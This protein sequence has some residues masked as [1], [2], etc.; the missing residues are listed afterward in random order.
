[1]QGYLTETWYLTALPQVLTPFR[2]SEASINLFLFYNTDD[3]SCY[4][5]QK[6]EAGKTLFD[7]NDG[8]IN[9]EGILNITR[10]QLSATEKENVWLERN[11]QQLLAQY[12]SEPWLTTLKRVSLRY[13]EIN[14]V[15]RE[16]A[17]YEYNDQFGLVKIKK[18]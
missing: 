10:V 6:D 14:M 1:M 12:L 18:A 13:G 4:F 8:V 2:K 3:D 17:Q 16:N 11:Y 7:I 5:T 9:R 15:K